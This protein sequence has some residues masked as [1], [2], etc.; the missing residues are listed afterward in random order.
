MVKIKSER[1]L[2]IIRGKML[3]GAASITEQKEIL[4]YITALESLVE[5]ADLDDFYGTEGYRH[6][7]G[8][9]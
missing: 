1:E 3:V 7:L 9:D 5:D 6:L 4:K 2:N 8:W